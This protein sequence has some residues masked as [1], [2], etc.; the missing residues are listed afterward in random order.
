VITFGAAVSG[1]K[2][3]P[4]GNEALRAVHSHQPADKRRFNRLL[5][6]VSPGPSQCARR[7]RR[8]IVAAVMIAH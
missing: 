8:L 1:E 7:L 3:R 5:G 2:W 4:N 6:R